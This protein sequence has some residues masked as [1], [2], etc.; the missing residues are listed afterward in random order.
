MRPAYPTDPG[1]TSALIEQGSTRPCQREIRAGVAAFRAAESGVPPRQRQMRTL[2]IE[3]LRGPRPPPS[4]LEG[5]Q[6]LSKR[7][8]GSR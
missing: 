2:Q 7:K 6:A 5:T 8:N 3:L 1:Q 4:R